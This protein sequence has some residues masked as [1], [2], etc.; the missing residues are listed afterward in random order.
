[1]EKKITFRLKCEPQIILTAP[2][3]LVHD[4]KDGWGITFFN[5]YDHPE[6]IIMLSRVW[7]KEDEQ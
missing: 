7:T 3:S 6:T 4:E 5:E 2:A 1:M